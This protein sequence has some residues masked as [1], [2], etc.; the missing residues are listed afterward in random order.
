M[1]TATGFKRKVLCAAEKL[2][3]KLATKVLAVSPSLRDKVI[4]EQI[5]EP[6]K[7]QVLGSG[8]ACGID[9]EKFNPDQNNR[10]RG[11]GIRTEFGI[12]ENA[13]VFGYVGRV[14]P[15]KGI[16]TLVE[17][18]LGLLQENPDAY[19]LLIG[20]FENVREKLDPDTFKTIKDNP[21]ILYN[22][23][24]VKDVPGY[25][26]AID[27]LVLPSKREGFG[28]TLIEAGAMRLPT[29]ATR[30]TGCK[31]AV[32]DGMT[33]ILVE[34][35]NPD[36]LSAAMNELAKDTQLR[37]KLGMQARTRVEK[38]FNSSTLINAHIKLYKNSLK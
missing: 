37:D 17:A 5:C 31:D 7:I 3:C 26:A 38:E 8:S 2:S 29:I 16:P 13:L 20:E 35:D 1:E 11:L 30:V 24:F 19:L 6:S 25:Y 36:E 34:P 14:V 4:E 32:V 10:D 23:V 18:F 12:P 22:N 33:G 21:N 15:D 9:L 28:L 27:V